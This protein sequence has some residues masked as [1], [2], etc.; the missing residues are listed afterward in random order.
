MFLIRWFLGLPT[1]RKVLLVLAPGM[2]TLI[3]DAFVAHW[4][5]SRADM[6]WNQWPP[7][8]YG[9]YATVGMAVLA[10][11]QCR[12]KTENRH[13]IAM[14]ILGIIVGTAGVY[15]HV[16]ELLASLEGEEM[17]VVAIG[18]TIALSP[19][20]FAPAAFSGVGLLLMV[21]KRMTGA[22][23]AETIARAREVGLVDT[24]EPAMVTD[25]PRASSGS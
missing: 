25:I 23:Q 11:W 10:L 19:P 1:H 16:I 8:L 13:L 20:V 17:T 2:V 22:S 18:K 3:F 15:F 4:S 6:H 7:V 12:G 24:G 5:W 21:L 9:V 14:G